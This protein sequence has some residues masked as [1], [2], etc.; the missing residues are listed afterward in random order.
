MAFFQTPDGEPA[1]GAP[2]IVQAPDVRT[3]PLVFASPHSGR[4]YTADFLAAASASLTVLRRS[5]DAYVDQIFA[6]VPQL[7]APLVC[8]AF[9]RVFVDVNRERSELDPELIE[10]LEAGAP[11]GRAAAGLGVIPRL[12]ADGRP[13]YRRKLPMA[14]VRRRLADCYAPYHDQL[15]AQITRSRELF[16]EAYLIDCHSMPAASARGADIVLGD[17][18]G[19]SCSRRFTACAEAH[20]RDLGF[21][22]VRNRP[23]AGG[24]T[25]QH[26]GRPNQG[27]HALQVEINR[28]LYLHEMAVRPSSGLPALK[29]AMGEW[30]ARL[31]ADITPGRMAAE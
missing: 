9:A 3:S 16:G 21:S 11:S 22:V 7:G 4:W 27:V 26:Y 28:G 24:Y 13:I 6:A 25:T 17:R 10:G 8:A 14:E 19:A 1:P 31:G 2:V 29:Q 12:A 20:L 18:F 23:Y 15:L 5:E 30:A